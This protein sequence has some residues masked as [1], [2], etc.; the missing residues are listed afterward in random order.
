M[1]TKLNCKLFLNHQNCC[2]P[3]EQYIVQSQIFS[4]KLTKLLTFCLLLFAGSAIAQ[5]GRVIT[6]RV[7][8]TP[9]NQ[10]LESVTVT[11]KGTNNSVTSTADGMYRIQLTRDN[12]ALVFSYV[13]YGSKE[14]PVGEA[15]TLN[16]TL[17]NETLLDEVV[18]TAFGIRKEKKS[19][20]YTVQS[21]N[22]ADLNVN[23]HNPALA[24]YERL[25]FQQHRE[26]DIPI[27][28]YWMN[29]YVMR[30]ELR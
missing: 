28:P 11:E 26:E 9:N 24:F 14:L 23:R 2:R 15:T 21:V 25:G 29:D 5:K 8:S 17:S 10:T 6:G 20:G 12:S 30:K 4:M 22:A 19:L 1:L 18:V 3:I 16:A 13:G 7:Y 27:G